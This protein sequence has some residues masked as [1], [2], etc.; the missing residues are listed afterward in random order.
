MDALQPTPGDSL[1]PTNGVAFRNS[2]S[3]GTHLDT[4]YTKP[5][6]TENASHAGGSYEVQPN[7][8]FWVI[9]EK[10]YGS[11]AYFKALAEHNR[12]KVGQRD[13]LRV[14]DSIATP[15][16][17]QLEQTYPDL[18]PKPSRR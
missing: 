10:V 12:G 2:G 17:A 16:I 11:G 6:G 4:D 14:G 7:D 9:S 8:N 13:K 5:F 18:C 1:R 3:D 15:T